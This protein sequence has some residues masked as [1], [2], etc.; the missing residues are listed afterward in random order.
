M[1]E[2]TTSA[3]I[4]P[5]RQRSRPLPNSFSLATPDSV[6]KQCSA[7]LPARKVPH[8]L[9]DYFERGTPQGAATAH[10][11]ISLA[12]QHPDADNGRGYN[13]WPRGRLSLPRVLLGLTAALAGD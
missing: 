13:H 2:A 7:V 3:E 8:G 1:K 6:R 10:H 12:C 4:S 11:R 9:N 5:A